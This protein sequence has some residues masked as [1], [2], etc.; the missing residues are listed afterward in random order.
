MFCYY[1][2]FMKLREINAKER[3]IK[4]TG[5]KIASFML[6]KVKNPINWPFSPTPSRGGVG[7]GDLIT[8]L[9][10]TRSLMEGE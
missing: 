4:M 7:R 9:P 5:V 10:L 8:S 2:I 6:S 3:E 1:C